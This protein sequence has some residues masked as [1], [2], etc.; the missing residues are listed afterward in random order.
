MHF[1][2]MVIVNKNSELYRSSRKYFWY[3]IVT[4]VDKTW[5][6]LWPSVELLHGKLITLGKFDYGVTSASITGADL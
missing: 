5:N 2:E 6:S 4:H 3:E 1:Y